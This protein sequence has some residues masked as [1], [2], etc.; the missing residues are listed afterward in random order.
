MNDLTLVIS[1]ALFAAE[2]HKDQRRKDAG[3]T[4]YINHP[5]Q[6]AHAIATIGGVTDARII[7]AALL[8]D[9]VEDCDVLPE[10]LSQRFGSEVAAIVAEVTDDRALAKPQRKQM[11]ITKAAT[12]SRAAKLVKL[13]D[14]LCNVRDVVQAQWT[15]ERKA[16][17]VAWAGQ[18]I[19]QIRG[20]NVAL[21]TAFDNAV[22]E[23]RS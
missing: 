20:T 13:G 22:T 12:K 4:P 16:E 14:K 17:Y 3:A 18:V 15:S 5:L 7:A 23:V 10:E 11:Q 21:E 1:A 2:Q 8:H 9:T 6:V 19:D